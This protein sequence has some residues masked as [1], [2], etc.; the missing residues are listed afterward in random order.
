MPTRPKADVS[1]F[2]IAP[3]EVKIHKHRNNG[4][5]KK[6]QY[7]QGIIVRYIMAT[8]L[9]MRLLITEALASTGTG[10][11]EQ[12]MQTAQNKSVDKYSEFEQAKTDFLNYI[13]DMLTTWYDHF[14]LYIPLIA[15]LMIIIGIILALL[16][17][18]SKRTRGYGI[19]M[20]SFSLI[21]FMLWLF[22]P[23]IISFG[24]SAITYR[25]HVT[26]INQG[27]RVATLNNPE[28]GITVSFPLDQ[29]PQGVEV[30]DYVTIRNAQDVVYEKFNAPPINTAEVASSNYYYRYVVDAIK[31]EDWD[32]VALIRNIDD[33]TTYTVRLDGLPAETVINDII[34]LKDG[35][36]SIDS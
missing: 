10:I 30:N 14:G 7:A 5:N 13:K 2:N 4:R 11:G 33:G 3:I 12:L 34:I 28:T 19:F 31:I 27:S 1:A 26:E 8:T 36:F 6:L 20:S 21:I 29:L 35:K 18:V 15:T 23:N 24:D 17:S 32:K 25:Y 16:T 22:M 9:F